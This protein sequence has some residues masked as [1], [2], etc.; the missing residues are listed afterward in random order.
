MNELIN[1]K[2]LRPSVIN[3]A[4][5]REVVEQD[6]VLPR[7]AYGSEFYL[8]GLSAFQSHCLRGACTGLVSASRAMLLRSGT[9]ERL[10]SAALRYF[11]CGRKSVSQRSARFT[12][13]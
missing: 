10:F 5:W 8:R 6:L 2:R 4:P 13:G 3:G 1:V 7:G 11:F 9:T 12:H